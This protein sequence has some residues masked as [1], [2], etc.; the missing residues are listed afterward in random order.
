MIF[1]THA[2][3]DDRQ[4]D[5][6]REELL[7]S[8]N[9]DYF[10]LLDLLTIARSRKHIEKYYNLDD[11][12]KFPERKVPVNVKEDIDAAGHFPPLKEVNRTIQRLHLAAYS[13]L[14]YILP[15]KR[16]EYNRKYDVMTDG[17]SIFKQLDREESLIHLMRI[18]LLKR[19]E[20]S[21]HS[22]SITIGKLLA[23]VNLL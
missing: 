13:P 19:M 20:S 1:D 14:K 8:M 12:G 22:F 3:Y 7:A 16:D 18:N 10:Q 23:A 21:I 9:F 17:G 4:F 11:V 2:H 15:G 6:D 5:S